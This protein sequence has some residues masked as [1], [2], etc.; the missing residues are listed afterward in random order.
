MQILKKFAITF[1]SNLNFFTFYRFNEGGTWAIE[2]SRIWKENIKHLRLSDQIGVHVFFPRATG[3][4]R[5]CDKIMSIF[6]INWLGE[7]YFI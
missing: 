1:L 5:F 3:Y 7:E 2:T 4:V 6:E